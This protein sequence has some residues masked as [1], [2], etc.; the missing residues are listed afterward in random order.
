MTASSVMTAPL[1]GSVSMPPLAI[2]GDAVQD[3]ERNARGLAAAMNWSDIAAS[4]MLMPPDAEPVMPA[5]AVTVI[6]SLTS[7][8]GIAVS[9]S[10]ITTKPGSSGDHPAEA[11][12][13][14]GVHR[15][16][17][18]AGDRRLGAFG[19]SLAHRPPGEHQHGQDAQQQRALDRPDRGDR[20]TLRH[21]RLRMP[22]E[23]ISMVRPVERG[24]RAVNTMFATPTTT[25]G[26]AAIQGWASF[27]SSNG[28]GSLRVPLP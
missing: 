21:E 26:R 7:G 14:R 15:R 22:G 1:C 28:S 6:A 27:S 19:E 23:V 2:G 24:I 17:Q 3:L 16:Q 20:V 9:A 4:A 5:S 11:V 10:R 13:R 12:F 25:S 18:R 8:L